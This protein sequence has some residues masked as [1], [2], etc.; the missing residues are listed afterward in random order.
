MLKKIIE[1]KVDVLVITEIKLDSTFLISQ[2]YINGFIKLYRLDRSKNG[3]EVLIYIF[4]QIP[5][6]E[7]G[8]L[9]P[10]AIERMFIELNLRK[11]KWL[12]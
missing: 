8:N 3:G 7:S 6:K 5:S 9:L 12:L 11:T 1:G 10:N 2:F 4:K